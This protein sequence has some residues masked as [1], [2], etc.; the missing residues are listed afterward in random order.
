VGGLIQ[1]YW[2]GGGSNISAVA[3][4]LNGSVDVTQIFSTAGAFAALRIDGSVVTWGASYGGN[5]SAVAAQLSGAVD[6][7]QI[8]S[9]V[10]A[11]AALRS[12]GSV[13]TWGHSSLGGDS[14]AVAEKIN[15]A[16][17]VDVT[18]IFSTDYAFAALRSDGSVV[19]WGYFDWGGD[20]SAVA[21]QLDGSVDVTQ[22]FSTV[23]AFAALRSD[24]SVVTWGHSGGDSSAVAAQLNGSVDVTQIFSTG[25]AFAALRSDGSVVTWG[26]S[27]SGGDSSAVAT[28]LNG[29]IDVMQIFSTGY[30]FAAL[31]SDGS[32]VTWGDPY[33]GGNSST[34]ATQL[35]GSVDV[36]QIFSTEYAFAAL[37]SDGSVV[38]WGDS[39]N[40]GD[41]SWVASQLASGVVSFANIYTNDVFEAPPNHAPAGTNATKTILEDGVYTFAAA[42]FGFSDANDSPANTLLAVKITTLPLAGSLKLNNVAV[43]AGQVVAVADINAGLLKFSPAANANGA[44]CANFTFQ[45]QDDGGTGN[46]GVD[47]DQ[48]P[49]TFTFNVT[50]VR[51]DLVLTG[52]LGNDTLNGDLIDAGSYG[53]LSGLAGDDTLNGLAGNDIL[54]GGTGA[55]TM[56]G[57]DGNDI[58]DVDNAGDSV[59]ETNAVLAT[60]GTDK[61]CSF[62]STY[63]LGANI[64]DLCILAT[65][66]ANG[67]GNSLANVIYA[68]AG[69][70]VLD[71]DAGSDTASYAYAF[72]GNVTV[73]LATTLSQA[74]GGSG[75]DTLLNFEN[76]TGSCYND[77]LTGNN[78]AN[79][80]NGGEGADTMIGGDGNDIY[81]VDNAGDSV[82]ET[83]AVLATGGTDTVYSYLSTYT[84]GANVENLRIL[85]TDAANGTGNSLNNV[86][87]AGVRNNTLSGLAGYD[88]LNGLFGNDIL[89]GGTGADTMAGGDGNDIYY[90]DNVGDSV[91]ETNAVFGG[92]DT[93]YSFL[94]TYTLGANVE[95]LRILATSAANGTGN[96]LNN[97]I[98][99]GTGNNVLNGG[100]G[101]DTASYAYA[102]AA[103]TASLATTLPQTI[104]GSGSDTLLNF[105]N[106]TGSNYHDNL[107]GNSAANTLNGGE[108][109]DTMAGS[110]GNDIYYVDNDWDSVR[111]TNAV[112]ATGGTDTVYSYLSTYTLGANVENL[113]ILAT[114]A[115]NGTGNSLNNVIYAGAGNNVLDGGDGNDTASYNCATAG[116][117]A[118]LATAFA[119]ATVS[120]GSDTL[121][122]FENLTGSDYNDTLTG[123]SAANTLNGGTGADTMIGGDGNDIYYV[124]DV[125]DSVSETNA[126][127]ATGGTDTVYSY[128]AS[129]IL[130]T[131]VENLRIVTAAASNGTGNGLNN[132]IFAGAGNNVLDGGDGNDTASY[133]YATV[134]VTASLATA[135]A[136]ATGGSGSDTLL[137]F[138]NLTGSNYNDTLTGN[139]AANVLNGGTGADTMTGGDGSDIYYVDN[140]ADVVSETNSVLDTGGTDAVYSYLG[141]YILGTNVENLRILATGIADC[142]GNSL[143]N[144]IYAGTGN[145]VLDGSDGNDTASYNYATAGI[146]ASLALLTPQTTGGSGN[147]TLFNFE[148]LTGSNFNDNLT[149]NGGSN[150]LT[151]G[152]G[153]DS[154]DGGAGTDTLKGEAGNDAYFVDNAG[155]VV[156]ENAG[157]GTDIVSS[158]VTYTLAANIENLTLTDA[159][160]INGTGNELANVLIGNS[161]ANTL[162]GGTG[163]DTLIGGDGNDIYYVEN[164]GDLVSETNAVLATGGM[165]MVYSYLRRFP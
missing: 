58:Y 6:V 16:S 159:S 41:S 93:V 109:A 92:T 77:N 56:A 87:Y 102:A 161:G 118:S 131:N 122:N 138:E 124:D 13:V 136:Q 38:T 71:G 162:N 86:I 119:Q 98:Y 95:D 25:Q 108:G 165:D 132:V 164:A 130:G 106:L 75:S 105:E 107:T 64:E 59:S 57:G 149:G 120:S 117:T 62:L 96:S 148:N 151:G 155:D 33:W 139:N 22:I 104:S 11:F 111:E 84:L 1:Q 69:N 126:V 70:N 72:S 17:M 127:L 153:N 89:D 99:A 85:A 63:T 94:S 112:L 78:A 55:D 113:R 133:N 141:T 134:G 30:A 42:N 123:N 9:T 54:D 79:T 26:S 76:L 81:Y 36:T 29:S 44:G 3:A 49:N 65:G 18:Q 23:S 32:V 137:N 163:A 67:T 31:R 37:R 90:V 52:T 21:A 110:D 160:A 53:T 100:A 115:A 101:S 103:V 74:T 48:S 128:L 129:Y 20:S 39:L 2:E 121:L 150:V 45:V 15:G 82:R 140:V 91:S 51:D 97:V 60:G 34:V 35:N 116:V 158:S 146:T 47:L 5:S 143:N 73:S 7:V 152:A 135:S 157:E 147:D 40:G 24:G 28:Q 12:N 145:N 8:F 142:T 83:N 114:D 14:S 4:Q 27:D 154:L 68:G 125:G 144:V 10:E 19:T 46:G 66:A 88:T 43:T 61:V 80:L 156:T 50:A